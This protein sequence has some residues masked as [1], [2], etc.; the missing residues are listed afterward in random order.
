MSSYHR[1]GQSLPDKKIGV[2]II[3]GLGFSRFE[4]FKPLSVNTPFGIVNVHM[5]NIAGQNIAVIPR[6][7]GEQK[8]VPPHRINYRANIWAVYELGAT[9]IISVN[10][11]G[12]MKSYTPGSLVLLTDFLDFTKNRVST[13]FDNKTVHV[14]VSEPYCPQIN[15]YLSNSII[16]RSI[17]FFEGVYACTEGP[18][19][20]TKSEIDMLSRFAD[21]V[22]M[23]GVPEVVLAKELDMC[24]ASIGLVT[25]YACGLSSKRLTVDEV[26]DV[27]DNAQDL[28][29]DV[30]SDTI[31]TL[32]EERNCSCMYATYNARI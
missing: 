17:D 4:N 18:R 13:F 10:S 28:L 14:D 26:I 6:H 3:G 27:V 7:G 16:N 31:Y 21:F 29:Y 12:T 9:R 23:T 24:Y 8:H 20:E 30:I 32:T 15:K 11:V 19:F 5:G 22:G 1:Q 2:V 25:N